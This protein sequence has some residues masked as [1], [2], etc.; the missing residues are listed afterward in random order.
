[1]QR[2][3]GLRIVVAAGV[4]S[5]LAAA[6]AWAET[7]PAARSHSTLK[8]VAGTVSCSTFEGAVQIDAI[9]YRPAWG[10]AGAFIDTGFPNTPGT[11]A[12]VGVQTDKSNYTLDKRCGR[13]K[14]RVRFTHRGLS[15]AGVVKA[16]YD[17]SPTVYC[18]AP[19]RVL[20]RYRFGLADSGKP[21]TAT[22]AVWAKRKH[23]SRLREIGYVQWTRSRSVSY[24]SRKSCT[25]QY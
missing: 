8:L 5:V 9:A 4:A 24:Y 20:V 2:C 21:A 19:R 10:Y 7:A 14:T 1:M 18:A 12:L 3:R 22:I 16:G 15:S 13:T 25:S 17:Q 23:S 11:I 6:G